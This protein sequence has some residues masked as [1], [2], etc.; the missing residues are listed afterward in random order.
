MPQ[1]T[2]TDLAAAREY[3]EREGG[4]LLDTGMNPVS[5]IHRDERHLAA[6]RWPGCELRDGAG[7]MLSVWC[8]VYVATDDEGI[9]VDQRGREF[10]AE[11]ERRQ[12]W[13]ET[14]A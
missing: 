4:W 8:R 7:P 10:I 6:G 5:S 12:C 3:L 2:T 13:D 14:V 11:C 9:V 1:I